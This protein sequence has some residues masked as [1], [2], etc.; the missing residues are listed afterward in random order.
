MSSNADSI[1]DN[2]GADKQA[3]ESK[4]SEGELGVVKKLIPPYGT[5]GFSNQSYQVESTDWNLDVYAYRQAKSDDVTVV[6]LHSGINSDFGLNI[7]T[8]STTPPAENQVHYPVGYDS[9][10]GD[11]YS[12]VEKNPVPFEIQYK[13]GFI[14]DS[15]Y[16][17]DDSDPRYLVFKQRPGRI[18][19]L[20]V[21][22]TSYKAGSS[23]F[24]ELKKDIPPDE[25]GDP[26][27]PHTGRVEISV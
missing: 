3:G 18:Y 6:V 10:V 19:G 17:V 1:P 15:K 12:C 24:I 13:T 8:L 2:T 14:L 23:I 26:F 16:I 21:F 11:K 9:M 4:P 7:F 20:S 25:I 22:N 5:Q 27:G